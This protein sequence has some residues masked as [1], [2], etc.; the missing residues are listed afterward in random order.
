MAR[1]DLAGGVAR[2]DGWRGE[3]WLVA[4]VFSILIEE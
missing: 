1:W 2:F 4:E 3:I